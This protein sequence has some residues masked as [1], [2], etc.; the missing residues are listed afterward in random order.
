MLLVSIN[1]CGGIRV[2]MEDSEMEDV[3]DGADGD[4]TDIDRSVVALNSSR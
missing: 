2:D 3:P 4:V 1:V